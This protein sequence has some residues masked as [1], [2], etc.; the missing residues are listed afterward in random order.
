MAL[1]GGRERFRAQG[2]GATRARRGGARGGRGRTY[3][4]PR[5][6]R[7]SRAWS[8]PPPADDAERAGRLDVRGAPRR[9]VAGR[10]GD[11]RR[12]PR[13]RP[14]RS[15]GRSR[16]SC[17]APSLARDR[18]SARASSASAGSPRRSTIRTSS[19]SSTRASSAGRSTSRCA[20]SRAP[21]SGRCWPRSGGSSPPRGRDHRPGRRRARRRA[22]ARARPP[23]RQAREHPDR[24]ARGG[25]RLPHRLRDHDGPRGRHR[26]D[27]DGVRGRHRPTTCRPSRRA[28]RDIDARADVYALG[29]VLYRALTGAV[30]YD[31]DSDVEKMWAHI[32]E[33]PPD[34][35]GIRPELPASLGDAV[36][37]A[38]A[39]FPETASRPPASSRTRRS[40]PSL[41]RSPNRPERAVLGRDSAA[42]ACRV[43]PAAVRQLALRQSARRGRR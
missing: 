17:F 10:G 11:G 14:R 41:R 3:L 4:D 28:A 38:L 24:H 19:R 22:P 9:R 26:P 34:L 39:K 31:K 33:P 30:V 7:G 27:E 25:A 16:S 23:R 13:H 6:V 18:C 8:R 42:A 36:E 12:L 29:C 15:T 32:H 43:A 20:T 1:S 35:L 21:T 37:R 2:G 5:W 40:P